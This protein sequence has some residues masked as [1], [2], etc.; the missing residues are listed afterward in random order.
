MPSAADYAY[1]FV[2]ARD[3][4]TYE[5]DQSNNESYF[6]FGEPVLAPADGTALATV[7]SVPDNFPGQLNEGQP[8]GNYVILDHGN[9]E[10]SVIAHLRK[11]SVMVHPGQHILAGEEIGRCGNSGR[12]SQP[13]VHYHLQNSATPGIGE[14]LPAQFLQY[15]ADGDTEALHRRE[16]GRGQY[17]SHCV[18]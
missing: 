1:D 3:Q 16:P 12:S 2:I 5:G 6:C 4:R 13:H 10:Y 17:V 9:A 15:C 14:G 18:E 11:D 8:L 7:E